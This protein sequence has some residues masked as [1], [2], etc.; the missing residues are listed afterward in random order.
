[1]ITR[2]IYFAAALVILTFLFAIG[3]AHFEE[4]AIV[5]DG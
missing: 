1:M 4:A 3:A 2:A 5:R